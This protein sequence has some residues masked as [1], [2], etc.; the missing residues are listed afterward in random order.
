[1]TKYKSSKLPKYKLSDKVNVGDEFY[2]IY[3]DYMVY[4]RYQKDD[5]IFKARGVDKNFDDE[6]YT[7]FVETILKSYERK[8]NN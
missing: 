1:M 6:K 4:I 7:N 8:I 3:L 2:V 5:T